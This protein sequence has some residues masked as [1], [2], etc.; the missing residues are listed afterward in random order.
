MQKE[1]IYQLYI[2][3]D[4]LTP[5]YIGRTKFPLAKRL[6]EHLKEAARGSSKKCISIKQLLADGFEIGIHELD[7]AESGKLCDLEQTHITNAEG[8]GIE[9]LNST[10]GDTD[11]YEIVVSDEPSKPWSIKDFESIDWDR[12]YVGCRTGEYGACV[13]GVSLYRKG[14]SKLRVVSPITGNVDIGG[15]VFEKKIEKLLEMVNVRLD[16]W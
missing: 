11:R 2:K 4:K 9:L 5:I 13:K 3:P 10:Q 8:R 14:W 1:Y 15:F 16:N 12:T 6:Q 7:C